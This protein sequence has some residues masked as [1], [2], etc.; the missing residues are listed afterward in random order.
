LLQRGLDGVR[1]EQHDEFVGVNN[2]FTSIDFDTRHFSCIDDDRANNNGA[3]DSRSRH[4]HRRQCL[5]EL[6]ES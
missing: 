6:H 1:R 5:W 3:R 4:R 2:L